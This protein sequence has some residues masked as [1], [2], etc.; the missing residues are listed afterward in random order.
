MAEAALVMTLKVPTT[1]SRWMNSN[2]AEVVGG[3]VA[4]DDPADP[5]G[6][7]A[8]DGDPQRAALGR[9]VDRPLAVLG[10]GD[11]AAHVVAADLAGHR[12]GP[13][14]VAVEDGDPDPLGGQGPGGGGPQ[15][16]G[17]AGDDG[18][19]S[20]E[21]HAPMVR[22]GTPGRANE[23]LQGPEVPCPGGSRRRWPAR[24]PRRSTGPRSG[25]SPRR[26]ATGTVRVRGPARA[27]APTGPGWPP[28]C[29]GSCASPGGASPPTTA[30]GSS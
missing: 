6:P 30:P 28:A 19:V 23:P 29:P 26:S 4:V 8:V 2:G 24:P 3:P 15:A 13:L 10:H 5:A 11:V 18:R 7:G 16:R 20:V 21:L 12:L 22:A 27:G 9:L 25:P 14:L 17:A 1:F